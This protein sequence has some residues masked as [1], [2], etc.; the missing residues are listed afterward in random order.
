MV[1]CFGGF[2]FWWFSILVVFY[3]GGFLFCPFSILAVFYFGGF[4]FWSFSVWSYNIYLCCAVLCSLLSAD[5]NNNNT[6]FVGGGSCDPN[7]FA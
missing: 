3:F 4:L 2:I 5:L 7:F 1:F 6:E